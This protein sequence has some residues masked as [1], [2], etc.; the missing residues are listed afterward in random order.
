MGQKRKAEIKIRACLAFLVVR[1]P[2][3]GSHC[4]VYMINRFLPYERALQR[5]LKPL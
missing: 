2:P 5:S 1:L 4:A 3:L